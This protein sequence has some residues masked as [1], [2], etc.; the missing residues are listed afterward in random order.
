VRLTLLL[1]LH[2]NGPLALH[3][4]PRGQGMHAQRQ[5][6]AVEGWLEDRSRN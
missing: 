1:V 3:H 5:V 4:H 6:A 2:A